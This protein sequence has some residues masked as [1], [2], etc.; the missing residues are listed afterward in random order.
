MVCKIKSKTNEEALD[1]SHFDEMRARYILSECRKIFGDKFTFN[2]YDI[3]TDRPG[4][5]IVTL[6]GKAKLKFICSKYS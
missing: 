3:D 4:I 1:F 6:D 5:E 2:V